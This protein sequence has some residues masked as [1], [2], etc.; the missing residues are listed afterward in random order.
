M[1]IPLNSLRRALGGIN[2]DD[3]NIMTNRDIIRAYSQWRIT[4]ARERHGLRTRETVG[5]VPPAVHYLDTNDD[6]SKYDKSFEETS[7][8][9]S[10]MPPQAQAQTQAQTQTRKRK[11]NSPVVH[12]L[13][14]RNDHNDHHPDIDL[15]LFDEE[16]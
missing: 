5:W 16:L 1:A 9:L 13:Q 2:A 8:W 6:P 7:T 3:L 14:T 4:Q 15:D 10:D 11:Y 12:P